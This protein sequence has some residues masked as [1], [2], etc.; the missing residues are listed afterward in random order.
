MKKRRLFISVF[1]GMLLGVLCILGV[2]IR[3]GF[4]GNEL[5]LFAMWYNRVLMGVVIGLA[6]D[7]QFIDSDWNFVVRGFVLGL[8]VTS[9]ISFTS[10]FLDWPSFFAGLVYGVVIDFV[11]TRY[12][13]EE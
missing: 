6:Y 1:M 5:F 2:G 9:A 12:G 3:I 8:L 7:I 13:V 4:A 11:A 10:G